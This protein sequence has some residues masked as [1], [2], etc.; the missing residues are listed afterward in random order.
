MMHY[1]WAHPAPGRFKT[2]RRNCLCVVGVM[3]ILH[4]IILHLHYALHI[5]GTI[6]N[7]HQIGAEIVFYG[8]EIN[9]K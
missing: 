1:V 4:D 2:G 9:N 8:G 6:I 7:H 3:N 5:C